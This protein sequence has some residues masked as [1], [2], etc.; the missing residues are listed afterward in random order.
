MTYTKFHKSKDGYNLEDGCK[1]EVTDHRKSKH[2]SVLDFNS[3]ETSDSDS[4]SCFSQTDMKETADAHVN[5]SKRKHSDSYNDSECE[6]NM[7]TDAENRLVIDCSDSDRNSKISPGS[8]GKKMSQKSTQNNNVEED[9]R[10][11]RSKARLMGK[12]SYVNQSLGQKPVQSVANRDHEKDNMCV[13]EETCKTSN[14]S[15]LEKLLKNVSCFDTED[16]TPYLEVTNRVSEDA[17]GPESEHI[18][19]CSINKS[20]G[21]QQDSSAGK[22]C[23]AEKLTNVDTKAKEGKMK[24]AGL[25]GSS[26]PGCNISYRL[27][28]LSKAEGH[29]NDRKEG[30]VKG[31]S[32][33]HEIKVLV[34]CKVDG[35]KVNVEYC[36]KC[37]F[38]PFLEL[39]LKI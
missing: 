25:I 39:Y 32:T 5:S 13:Y 29:P 28:K 19:S 9:T 38:F 23:S 35:H 3:R 14:G 15:D 11:T 20:A 34:R 24:D 36:I 1:L 4:E 12:M 16:N 7:S 2:D 26:P 6:S 30:F 18:G 37:K 21:N 17:I 8:D 27:W 22:S 33:N 10:V 31:D